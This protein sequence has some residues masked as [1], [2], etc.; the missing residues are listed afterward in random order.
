VAISL[1]EKALSYRTNHGQ[2]SDNTPDTILEVSIWL[3]LIKYH[4]D[5]YQDSKLKA[6]LDVLDVLLKKLGNNKQA[7]EALAETLYYR[8]KS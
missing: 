2:A 5:S 6:Q 7:Q 3:K 4:Y 8:G 1:Y